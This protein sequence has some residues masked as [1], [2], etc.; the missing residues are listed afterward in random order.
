MDVTVN[1]KGRSLDSTC[2]LAG[3][4]SIHRCAVSAKANKLQIAEKILK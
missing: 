1:V 2:S 4:P 3:D